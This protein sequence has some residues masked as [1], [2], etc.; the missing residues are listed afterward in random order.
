MTAKG[1]AMV[2]LFSLL[3]SRSRPIRG[4]SAEGF[5]ACKPLV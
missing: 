1:M 4:S 3:N 5:V 2:T